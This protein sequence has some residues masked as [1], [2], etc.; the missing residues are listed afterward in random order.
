[1]TETSSPPLQKKKR[2]K[3]ERELEL[4]V[5]H[6]SSSMTFARYCRCPNNSRL[7][8]VNSSDQST[9]GASNSPESVTVRTPAIA[10]IAHYVPCDI[11]Q[12]PGHSPRHGEHSGPCPVR[13]GGGVGGSTARLSINL[14]NC[15]EDCA[16]F[17]IF[18]ALERP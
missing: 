8:K 5:T 17:A 12:L 7:C 2:K 10:Q 3:R 6:T 9:R 11:T 1:M 16:N 14:W 18:V 4:G 13:G 15:D